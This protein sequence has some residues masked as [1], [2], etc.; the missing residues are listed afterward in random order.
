MQVVHDRS[1]CIFAID[2]FT[3]LKQG[4]QETYNWAAGL[5]QPVT[6]HSAH[7][8]FQAEILEQGVMDRACVDFTWGAAQQTLSFCDSLASPRC[9][10]QLL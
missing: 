8:E 6:V 5:D 2:R 3:P 9:I 1:R 4:L 7:Q 10:D